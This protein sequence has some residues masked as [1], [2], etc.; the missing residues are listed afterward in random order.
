MADTL[1]PMVMATLA[2][3]V[4]LEA[5]P[6]TNAV[7]AMALHLAG[8]LDAG[9]ARSQ[10]AAVAREMR[11]CLADLEATRPDPMDDALANLMRG[12]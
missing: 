3:L 10:T 12:A 8:V 4:E 7:A 1:T 2:T 9:A 6:A 5:D 11:Q